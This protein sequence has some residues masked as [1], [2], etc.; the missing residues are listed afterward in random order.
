MNSGV[1]SFDEAVR[2]IVDEIPQANKKSLTTIIFG[3]RVLF[4]IS[5]SFSR[6]QI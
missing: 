1:S 3:S 5:T 6:N 2:P 4:N